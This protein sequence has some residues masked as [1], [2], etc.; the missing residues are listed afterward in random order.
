MKERK[1]VKK[2][3]VLKSAFYSLLELTVK[4]AC[5]RS[6]RIIQWGHQLVHMPS[7]CFSCDFLLSY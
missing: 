5:F 1:I 3:L 2:A 6:S 7:L 4:P